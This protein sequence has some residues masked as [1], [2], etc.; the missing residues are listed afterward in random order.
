[1]PGLHEETLRP[2]TENIRSFPIF[3]SSGSDADQLRDRVDRVVHRAFN[4]QL[5]H[6]AWQVWFPIWRWEDV[7]ARASK[8]GQTVNDTF[9][10]MARQSSVVLVLLHD[11]LRPG[12]K[13]ELLAVKDDDNVDLKVFWFPLRRSIFRLGRPTEVAR[14]LELHKNEILHKRFDDVDGEAAWIHLVQ[15]LVATML[16]ALRSEE[17]RPYV[18]LR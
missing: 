13:A 15:N 8:S 17:R 9:V 14:F 2:H 6:L 4:A 7:E 16:K 5:S 10:Q 18:E 1:M 12:T 11:R 3:I